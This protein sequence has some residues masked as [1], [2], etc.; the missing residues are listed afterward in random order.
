VPSNIDTTNRSWPWPALYKH[1]TEAS[2]GCRYVT[3]NA[4]PTSTQLRFSS[5]GPH[6]NNKENWSYRVQRRVSRGQ[7]H[8]RIPQDITFR[9]VGGHDGDKHKTKSRS[10]QSMVGPAKHLRRPCICNAVY[11]TNPRVEQRTGPIKLC[12]QPVVAQHQIKHTD[13][14]AACF[15]ERKTPAQ[16]CHEL[17]T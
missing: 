1:K 7:P 3:T 5:D 4:Y 14:G 16:G 11:L 17:L 12:S 2:K 15:C 10:N 9:S 6:D 8:T 13:S